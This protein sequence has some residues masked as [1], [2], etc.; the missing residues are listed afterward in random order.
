[1]KYFAR[2]I[3]INL[4]IYTL[5]MLLLIASK[6]EPAGALFIFAHAIVLFVLSA[7]QRNRVPMMTMQPLTEEEI[8]RSKEIKSKRQAYLISGL[9]ILLIGMPVCFVVGA[10]NLDFR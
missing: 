7:S 9:L 10:S 6:V 3:L 2:I 5:Y 8:A 1:M 4:G